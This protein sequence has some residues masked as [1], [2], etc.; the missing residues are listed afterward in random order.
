MGKVENYKIT[1]KG[2]T[3]YYTGESINVCSQPVPHGNGVAKIENGDCFKGSF[4]YG[5]PEEGIYY[6]ENGSYCGYKVTFFN[7]VKYCY[8]YGYP[9]P[10][11]HQEIEEAKHTY[12]G[13]VKNGSPN[14]IGK[15]TYIDKGFL[16]LSTRISSYEGGFKNGYRHGV[17]KYTFP[18]G[19]YDICLYNEGEEIYCFEKVEQE[20]ESNYSYDL[21]YNNQTNR[22]TTSISTKKDLYQKY[23][24]EGRY[25]DAYQI[26]KD[27][28]SDDVI[29]IST[30]YSTAKTVSELM[31]DLENKI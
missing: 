13:E 2:K 30:P 12:V 24:N 26:L 17:G 4:S 7:S 21:S 19:D 29:G 18:S 8:P 1:F 28:E 16:G 27:L 25:R 10:S 5:K 20:Q 6:F 15:I 23:M 14:G 22:D 31:E 11:E 3:A 9:S